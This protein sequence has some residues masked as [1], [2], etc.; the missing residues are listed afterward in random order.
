[1]EEIINDVVNEVSKP[2]LRELLLSGGIGVSTGTVHRLYDRFINKYPKNNLGSLISIMGPPFASGALAAS[3]ASLN[4]S[5]EGST[6]AANLALGAY[7][8][9]LTAFTKRHVGSQEEWI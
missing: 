5:E 3:I 8:H 6:L 1:M 7:A 2:Y 4:G 9:Y